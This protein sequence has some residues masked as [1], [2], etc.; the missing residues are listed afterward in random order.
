MNYLLIIILFIIFIQ[1]LKY[2]AV[3]WFLFPIVLVIGLIENYHSLLMS[4]TFLKLVSLIVILLTL[5]VYISLKRKQL[6]NIINGFFSLGDILFLFVIIPILSLDQYLLFIVLSSI[7]SLITQFFVLKIFQKQESVIPY[8]G[9]A[10]L[11]LSGFIFF[12]SIK[13]G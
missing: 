6:T 2:R 9:Y 1:D 12:N 11:L 8:A 4:G 7:F 5:T 10:A 13:I 3:Y